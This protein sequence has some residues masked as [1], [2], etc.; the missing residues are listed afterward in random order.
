MFAIPLVEASTGFAVPE[1]ANPFPV[2]VDRSA[3]RRPRPD[4]DRDAATLAGQLHRS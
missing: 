1:P 4:T 2:A 3:E